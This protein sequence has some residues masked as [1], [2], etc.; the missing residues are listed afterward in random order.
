VVQA[1][2]RFRSSEMHGKA[3]QVL[4]ADLDGDRLQDAVFIDDPNMTVYFQRAKGGFPK[5]P[6]LHLAWEE[7]P[8]VIWPARMGRS[9]QS[10]LSMTAQGV[11]EW[12][13]TNPQVLPQRREIIKQP[14]TLPEQ[15]EKSYVLQ[16]RMS[17]QTTDNVPLVLVP[18]GKDLQVWRYQ[19]AWR[20]M[21][22]LK[23]MVSVQVMPAYQQLGYDRSVALN[24]N[25][26]DVNADGREDLVVRRSFW[27]SQCYTMF[28][29]NDQGRLIEEPV[30]GHECPEQAHTWTAW[31]DI[32]RDGRVDL[33]HN[34]WLNEPWFI[35]GTRS[36]KVLVRI[37]AAD[38]T[39]R[40]PEQ[41][42]SV[43]RK[44]DWIA[45]VPVVDIDG[46]GFVDLV[47]GYSLFDSREGIRKTAMAKQLDFNLKFHFYRPGQG[48]AQGH[49]C[50]RDLVIHL[51][52]HSL[53]LTWSRR[54]SFQR[55]INLTGDFD[56]D[57]D[58]DVLVRDHDRKVSAYPFIS[59]DR[60]FGK[61]ACVQFNYVGSVDWFDVKDLNG[62]GVSDLISKAYARDVLKVFLSQ[63]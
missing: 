2:V 17:V 9:G 54:R 39:G 30:L 5:Q 18:V 48:Y 51:D 26:G 46:D 19:Q 47:L 49:D 42:T 53:H 13:F 61:R 4:F 3:N 50:Q 7:R 23:D 21:Q 33:I 62:D 57:G 34:T 32:N 56:G 8:T 52:R 25:V 16:K 37:F 28:L 44:N 38:A 43:F 35:P 41:P 40:L 10:L 45:A 60:G 11:Q 29:Q 31:V 55:F 27:G 1:K 12:I 58:V 15:V 63:K 6:N 36:G 59:R 14:T 22:T 20:P 24:L